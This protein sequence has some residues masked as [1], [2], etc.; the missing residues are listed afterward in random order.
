MTISACSQLTS[1]HINEPVLGLVCQFSICLVTDLLLDPSLVTLP[2][3]T[4]ASKH[5]C[6]EHLK[7]GF[8]LK[9]P[10][11]GFSSQAFQSPVLL[12]L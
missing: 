11:M 4:S 9:I 6:L 10:E 1:F 5:G 8:I 7:D 3:G 12:F 2:C